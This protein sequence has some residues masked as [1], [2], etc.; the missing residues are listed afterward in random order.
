MS[1]LTQ[2]KW[3]PKLMG[4]DFANA[5]KKGVDNVTADALFRMQNPAKLLSIIGSSTITTDFQKLR[6]TWKLMIGNDEVLRK[7]LLQQVHRGSVGVHSG[8]KVTTHKLCSMFY[9]KKM[10]REV[11][12][13]VRD[14]EVCQRYKPN[15][16]AYPCLLQPL[17]IPIS[18]WT[19]ISMDFIEGLPKSQGKDVI[20]V[21]VDILNRDK[22]FVS[23]FWKELFKLLQ[24]QLNMSIAYHPQSDGQTE[25]V[26]RCLECYLRCMTEEQPKQ[27]MKWLSLAEWWYNTNFHT[28]IHTTPYEA[29]YGK[30]P[31]VHIPYVGGESKV[32]LV[33]KTLSERETAMDTLKSHIS[34]AQSRMKSHADKGRTDKKHP[35]PNQVCGNLPPCDNSGVFLMEPVAVLDRRMARKGNGVEFYV[36]VQWANR[37][38]EDATW[39]SVTDLQVKFSNFDCTA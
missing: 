20:L 8:V 29:V 38:N 10:R 24:V 5:Y 4:F 27:W 26:N 34:R 19:S 17:S 2:L 28:S 14:C 33:D 15:L 25:V 21:V 11:K 18:I 6:G 1:T 7:E 37:N 22:I 32:D 3:L 30:P 23:S 12:K 9:W 31:P 35:S 16:E 39:E 36:L 13:F